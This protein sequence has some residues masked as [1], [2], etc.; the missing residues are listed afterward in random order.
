M[1]F[2]F[3]IK[4]R[5]KKINFVDY[6]SRRFNYHDVNIKIIRFLFILQTKFYIIVFLH[7]KFSSIRAIIVAIFS[8][9]SRIIFNEKKSRDQKL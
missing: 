2:N 7:I 6:L 9:I 1:N 4:Y 5:L 3:I 8:K